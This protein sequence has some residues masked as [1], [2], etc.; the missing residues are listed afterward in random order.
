MHLHW[1]DCVEQYKSLTSF[2]VGLQLLWILGPV[3]L[4]CATVAVLLAFFWTDFLP[5]PSRATM[6]LLKPDG[7]SQ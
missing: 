4:L 2:L 6:H 5:A 7:D 1:Q 3:A